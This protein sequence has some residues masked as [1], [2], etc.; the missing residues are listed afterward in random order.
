MNKSKACTRGKAIPVNIE[1]KMYELKK[2]GKTFNGIDP[3]L[4]VKFDNIIKSFENK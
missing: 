4:I 2:T 1:K 3:M